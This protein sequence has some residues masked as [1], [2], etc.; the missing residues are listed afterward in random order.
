MKNV[1][2]VFGLR[3]FLPVRPVV[4]RLERCHDFP[5]RQSAG[6]HEVALQGCHT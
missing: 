4:Q 2:V 5:A 6:S 1:F 3:L